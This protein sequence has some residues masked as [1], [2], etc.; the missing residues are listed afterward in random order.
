MLNINN[1]INFYAVIL[2]FCLGAPIYA[3]CEAGYWIEAVMDNGKLIK[4]QDGS[5]WEV[6]DSDTSTSALWQRTTE[7][8][9]CDNK[10]INTE[11]NETVDASKIK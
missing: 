2:L 8:V 4:L 10:L 11:D 1:C 3:E 7:I 9:V 5:I 6:S